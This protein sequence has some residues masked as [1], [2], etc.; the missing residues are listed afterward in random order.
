MTIG[1]RLPTEAE[2]EFVARANG[3]DPLLRYPWGETYP[4]R[5]K[6]GNFADQSASRI[7]ALVIPDYDDGFAGPRPRRL[8][9]ANAF[10]IQDLGGNVAEWCHDFYSIPT[11]DAG[12][13]T[14]D[15]LG[16]TQRPTPRACGARAGAT[17]PSARFDSPIATTAKRSEMTWGFGSA[18]TPRTRSPRNEIQVHGQGVHRTARRRWCRR[19]LAALGPGRDAGDRSGAAPAGVGHSSDG[20]NRRRVG[21]RFSL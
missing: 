8:V 18:G 10:G 15:P 5:T 2:W 20:T 12:K 1:Y 7:L 13:V 21:R 17:R 6:S 3:T 11:Y 14:V 19:L 9:S 16:P 4:P